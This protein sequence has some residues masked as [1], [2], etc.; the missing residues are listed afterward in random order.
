MKKLYAAIALGALTA[1]SG[2]ADGRGT[3]VSTQINTKAGVAMTA[4]RVMP[5]GLN[6]LAKAPARGAEL[7]TIED[8]E[9]VYDVSGSSLLE[10]GGGIPGE[11]E[12][13]VAN[14]STGE[15][16]ISGFP[17]NFTLKGVLDVEAKTLTIPNDQ[18]LGKDSYGDQNYFYLKDADAE[19]KLIAGKSSAA[20]T[21]GT[22][23]ANGVI[24]FPVLDIW[25]IGDYNDEDLGWWMLGYNMGMALQLPGEDPEDPNEGWTTVGNATVQ[26]GWIVPGFGA[27]QSKWLYECELQ[28]KVDNQ[29]VYRLVDPYK[30]NCPVSDYNVSTKIG[31]I[32]FDVTD[33]EHVYFEPVEAGYNCPDMGITKLYCYNALTWYCMYF[34]EEP[35]NMVT[36]IKNAGIDMTWTTFKDRCVTVPSYYDESIDPSTNTV[37]GWVNDACFGY[38]SD[39]ESCTG[40]RN[41]NMEAKI[42][43]PDYTG[44][45]SVNTVEE[46]REVEYYNLQGIRVEN[47]KAGVYV[48]R[49]GNST[50]KRL[51]R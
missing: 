16:V 24:T 36:M 4:T 31:Y 37:I 3:A 19:G 13:S 47:P 28:Q 51:F 23:G 35:A 18:D 38:N 22:I 26:D 12:I 5:A 44:V 46:A 14:T 21:V 29:N 27:D 20:A 2:W 17:Q 50:S 33:P 10:G 49:Q 15:V 1:F 30:G 42:Y 34:D 40:W 48:V 43:F 6:T 7:T 9:G 45:E 32:Q 25:A 11:V 39:I 41:K 8:Y